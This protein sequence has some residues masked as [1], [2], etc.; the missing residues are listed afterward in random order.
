MGL[1]YLRTTELT[2]AQRADKYRLYVEAVQNPAADV[3]FF[4][5]LYEQMNGRPPQTIREDFCG[6]AAISCEWLR[7]SESG[8]AIAIDIDPEPI[9][10]CR[11]HHVPALTPQQADRL[12]L[13][14]RDVLEGDL[15]EADVILAP[16][17]S[18]C[19]LRK[20]AD[21]VRYFSQCRARLLPGGLFIMDLYAGPEAQRSGKE[22]L[23]GVACVGIWE[24][25][26]F[27]SIT[28]EAVNRIHFEFADASRLNDAFVFEMRMWSPAEL[29]DALA[30]V[31][32]R[33]TCTYKR[34]A[35]YS[36]Q[37][38]AALHLVEQIEVFG[39]W[40]LYIVGAA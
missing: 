40:E 10:W 30:E 17:T 39:C 38:Q 14:E 11:A 18:I 20:R 32:F 23:P 22:R 4:S 5:A 15:P 1:H 13:I 12:Q 21:L 3:R 36:L 28:N 26:S 9:E 24:Q 2:A 29:I 25:A 8:R 33:S 37:D 27:N 7:H 34:S 6:T 31:G 35:D 19:L 16:N